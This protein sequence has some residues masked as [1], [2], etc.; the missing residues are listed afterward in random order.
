MEISGTCY[1]APEDMVYY[2]DT[3]HNKIMSC[4]FEVSSLLMKKGLPLFPLQQTSKREDKPTSLFENLAVPAGLLF[5]KHK[6]Q[7]ES[8]LYNEN[9]DEEEKP[10]IGEDIYNKLLQRME[11]NHTKKSKRAKLHGSRKT[12][13]RDLH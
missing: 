9:D 2:K 6:P 12:K 1:I 10:V 13:K 4:G 7:Q 3:K 11:L 8:F 5:H